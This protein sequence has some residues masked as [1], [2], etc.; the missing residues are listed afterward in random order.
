MQHSSTRKRC[1]S[2]CTARSAPAIGCSSYAAD[3]AHESALGT[4]RD[5]LA[6]QIT[7]A[8]GHVDFV[9]AYQ[10]SAPHFNAVEMALAQ[11]A[12]RDGS[13]WLLSSS[14]A[15][16]HL[17]QAL[18]GQPWAAAQALATHPRIAQAARAVGFG[19]VRE[20]RPALADVVASIESGA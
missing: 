10:R 12:A 6:Q 20:C 5:W 1:G 2:R 4:G 8:G 9:A 15:V 16:A 11:Q 7:A 18:P 19:T 13:V 17:A 14:E 3:G